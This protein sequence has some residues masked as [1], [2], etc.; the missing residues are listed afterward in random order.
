MNMQWKDT[1]SYLRRRYSAEWCVAISGLFPTEV[2]TDLS[3]IWLDSVAGESMISLL[4]TLLTILHDD[5]HDHH[6]AA[7][8]IPILV[9]PLRRLARMASSETEKRSDHRTILLV[10]NE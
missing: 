8:T 6:I 2:A 7:H 10:L 1:S 9:G 4:Q 3:P 5:A